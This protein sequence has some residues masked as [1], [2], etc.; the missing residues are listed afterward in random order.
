MDV[1]RRKARALPLVGLSD[2]LGIRIFRPESTGG[3][4]RRRAIITVR[5]DGATEVCVANGTFM[6]LAERGKGYK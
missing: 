6:A 3:I 5:R 1:E 4:E 2:M